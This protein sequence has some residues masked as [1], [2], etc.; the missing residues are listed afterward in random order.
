MIQWLR[1]EIGPGLT[2]ENAP[3][4][5]SGPHWVLRYLPLPAP[6]ETAPGEDVTI[7][8]WHTLNQVAIWCEA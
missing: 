1:L 3:G 2:Y 6:R 4:G 8:G 5:D 7:D